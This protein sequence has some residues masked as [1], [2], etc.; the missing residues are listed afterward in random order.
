MTEVTAFPP[1]RRRRIAALILLTIVLHVLAIH[2]G[3]DYFNAAN[4]DERA[5]SS[6]SVTL[7]P[8]ELPRQPVSLPMAA[9]PRSPKKPAKPR[10]PAPPVSPPSDAVTAVTAIDATSVTASA[11]VPEP[12]QTPA[13][14][15]EPVAPKE[16][17]PAPVQGT[18]YQVDPPPS[19]ELEYDVLAFSDNLTWHGTST[20]DWK[21]DGNRYTVDGEVYT[22]LFA[23]IAFLNFTSSGEIGAFGVEPELY[24]EKKRNRAATNTH[25]NRERNVV[26]FSASTT[27]YPRAGGEQDRASLIWQLAAIGRGDSAKFVPGAVIDMF[28]AGVRD[29]EVWRMQVVGQEE[30]RLITGAAQVWHVVRQPRPGSYEQRLDIWLEPGRQW[31]PARLRFTET[32]GDYLEL[33][34]SGLKTP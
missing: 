33:S 2:W 28:V 3:K 6:V 31:Y 30:I 32:N 22:R 15:A 14:T 34:L 10:P 17:S 21:T 26:S 11:P 7:H 25:F 18:Q 19:A 27:T 24:T 5:T 23:K 12:A 16:D 1:T 9:A 13:A 8:L 4:T 20:L 29:G